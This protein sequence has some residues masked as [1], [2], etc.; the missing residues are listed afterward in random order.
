M[1]RKISDELMKNGNLSLLV[2]SGSSSWFR[3]NLVFQ[4]FVRKIPG[5]NHLPN[6]RINPVSVSVK[7]ILNNYSI[8]RLRERAKFSRYFRPRYLEPNTDNILK[9]YCY[10]L[11]TNFK[12][13]LCT[14]SCHLLDSPRKIDSFDR[15]IQ[16]M[17]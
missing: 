15:L 5:P 3:Q 4:C 16:I 10:L 7:K 1:R 12:T 17:F 6:Q 8:E 9:I 13:R 11:Y 14:R 2:T